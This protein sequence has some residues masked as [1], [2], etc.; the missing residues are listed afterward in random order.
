MKNKKYLI[1]ILVIA[2]LAVA[3]VV[4]L[5][6]LRDAKTD[7]APEENAGVSGVIDENWTS[8]IN[9]GGVQAT[10]V[11]V[12]GY[13]DARMKAGD[14]TLHL[15]IG[16]PAVNEA[17]FYATVELED[18]TVLYESPLL[19]PGSGIKDIPLAVS[20]ERGQ[21]NAWVIYRVVSLDEEHTPM[22]SVRSAFILYVE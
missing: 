19:E 16:N 17:G 3:V 10:G 14:E 9:T 6:K 11:Q 21:Y 4:L 5:L 13:K 8:G 15:S 22:N 18:G 1:L 2:V 12:P 20:P 7:T